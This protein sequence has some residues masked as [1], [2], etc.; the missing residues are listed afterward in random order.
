M[1]R[2]T[3]WKVISVNGVARQKA[4]NGNQ[5]REIEIYLKLRN[6]RSERVTCLPASGE[7]KHWTKQKQTRIKCNCFAARLSAIYKSVEFHGKLFPLLSDPW[8]FRAGEGEQKFVVINSGF[9]SRF[10]ILFSEK[11]GVKQYA[12]RAKTKQFFHAS[13]V[14]NTKKG[15]AHRLKAVKLR[16]I[17]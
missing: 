6:E 17:F 2:V 4:F 14:C 13:C 16:N 10:T 11:R 8:K 1:L 12:A 3:K 15:E 7:Q 9:L 5:N